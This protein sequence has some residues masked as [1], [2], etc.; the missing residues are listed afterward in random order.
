[1]T[2]HRGTLRKTFL[3]VNFRVISLGD[4]TINQLATIIQSNFSKTITMMNQVDIFL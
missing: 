3:S 2:Y 4:I 1:M